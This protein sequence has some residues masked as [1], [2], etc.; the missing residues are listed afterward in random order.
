M[1]GY[2]PTQSNA[3]FASDNSIMMCVAWSLETRASVGAGD[4]LTGIFLTTNRKAFSLEFF[5]MHGLAE[6]RKATLLQALLIYTCD[7]SASSI[8]P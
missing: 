6:A 2:Q 7:Q 3:C 8:D 5:I 4:E 1:R